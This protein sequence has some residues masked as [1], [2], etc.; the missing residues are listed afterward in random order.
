MASKAT[1]KTNYKNDAYSGNRKFKMTNNSD[2]TVSFED[3][4]P[5]TQTGDNF[6]AAELNSFAEAINESAD[7]N[8][9]MN[10]LAGI[11]SNQGVSKFVGALAIK[12]LMSKLTL[13]FAESDTVGG[14]TWETSHI[15]SFVEGI[16]YAFIVTV[17]ATLDSNNSKQEITC[18]LNDVIIGQD[19][20]NN[21]ISS[22]FMG[23]CSYGDTIAVSSY[24][25]SGS[26]TK[27][28]SRVLCFP[29]AVSG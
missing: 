8:D 12:T 4:T 3:V 6:G 28:Q 24:K 26:W 14:V 2:G 17:S 19:G 7:K 15:T 21:K 25:D 13:P 1:L 20:N 10:D 22:V 16:N 5:Y 23:L 29:V 18:K 11:N 27:F 9:L